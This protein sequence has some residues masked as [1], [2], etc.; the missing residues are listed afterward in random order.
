MIEYK[1]DTVEIP[2]SPIVIFR[3]VNREIVNYLLFNLTGKGLG[4]RNIEIEYSN[5]L[6][7]GNIRLL[8]FIIYIL[9]I[10]K[11]YLTRFVNYINVNITISFIIIKYILFY[12]Y[13]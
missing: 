7:K 6:E 1:F 10:D 11:L 2:A 9:L 13:F 5:E 3:I 8:L 4:L 12:A